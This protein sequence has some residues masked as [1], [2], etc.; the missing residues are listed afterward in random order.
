MVITQRRECAQFDIQSLVGCPGKLSV[1][2]QRFGPA[3]VDIVKYQIVALGDGIVRVYLRPFRRIDRVA[4]EVVEK[5][6]CCISARC[7]CG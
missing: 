1:G 2:N 5:L 4:L 3:I 6:K 7:V